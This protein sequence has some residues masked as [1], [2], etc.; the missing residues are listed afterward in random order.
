MVNMKLKFTNG[1]NRPERQT[2]TISERDSD[3]R[4]RLQHS[5]PATH[6]N[7]FKSFIA[8]SCM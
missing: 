5:T 7:R 8:V 3:P 1:K 4:V 6:P 2:R